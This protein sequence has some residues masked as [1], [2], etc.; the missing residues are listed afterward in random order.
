MGVA[1]SR[2]GML[3]VGKAFL[4]I[5]S[6]FIVGGRSLKLRPLEKKHLYRLQSGIA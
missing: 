4:A 1:P 6:I 2:T 3:H 5:A